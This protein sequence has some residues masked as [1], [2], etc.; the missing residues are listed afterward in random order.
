M[1]AARISQFVAVE[2]LTCEA[3][4]EADPSAMSF[5]GTLL[6]LATIYLNGRSGRETEGKWW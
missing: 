2:S 3:A 6:P 5:D 4:I 1:A